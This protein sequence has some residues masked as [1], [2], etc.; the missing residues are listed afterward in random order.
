MRARAKRLHARVS[1]CECRHVR[2]TRAERHTHICVRRDMCLRNE[3]EKQQAHT[4]THAQERPHT[5]AKLHART[6]TGVYTHAITRMCTQMSACFTH[7][8]GHMYSLHAWV[9]THVPRAST[10]AHARRHLCVRGPVCGRGHMRLCACTDV[11]VCR[12]FLQAFF[13]T[14]LRVSVFRLSVYVCGVFVRTHTPARQRMCFHTHMCACA[15]KCVFTRAPLT[16][17]HA[18]VYIY[19]RRVPALR[20]FR[21]VWHAHALALMRTR[22]CARVLVGACTCGPSHV[23][24]YISFVR[25][26][27]SN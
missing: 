10:L 26:C 2:R 17:V 22:V 27:L 25:H 8:P 16:C 15:R 20:A 3:N 14:V 4:H 7:V 1:I 5:H 12:W 13:R 19:T 24:M 23:R 18:A 11:Y 9:H 21:R 6:D